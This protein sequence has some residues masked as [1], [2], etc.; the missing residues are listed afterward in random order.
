[1]VVINFK[2]SL[3]EYFQEMWTL[4][5][6][7]AYKQFLI[8]LN[9][10]VD[11]ILDQRSEPHL[12]EV[13][14]KRYR[15]HIETAADIHIEGVLKDKLNKIIQLKIKDHYFISCLID[16]CLSDQNSE[17]ISIEISNYYEQTLQQGP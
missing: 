3:K 9:S 2:D 4:E 5:I 12:R 14:W 8:F 7:T 16:K 13:I 15:S 6:E 11:K 17:N 1:M 10:F